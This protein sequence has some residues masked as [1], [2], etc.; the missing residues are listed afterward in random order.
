MKKAYLL[1]IYLVF[2]ICSHI[3]AQNGF[4]MCAEWEPALG[5]L[6]RWPLGIPSSLVVELAE[7][8]SLYVLVENQSQENQAVSNFSSWGV[9]LDH[10]VFIY[11]DTYSHWTRDWGPHYTFDENGVGGITDP[12][13]NGY[14]WVDGCEMK[15][16]GNTDDPVSPQ[17]LVDAKGYE[18]DDAVNGELASEFGC[19]IRFFPAYLT[20]GNIMVDGHF[21]AIS[22]DQML[23]ENS[24]IC[25]ETTFRSY[26]EDHLGITN[27]HFVSNPEVHGIQHIDC[28]AK[29][30]DEE[31]VLVKQVDS[32]HEEYNCIERLAE[33]ISGLTTCYGR[34]VEVKRIYCGSY[35]GMSVAA[36]TNSLIMNGKVLVPMFGIFSDHIALGTFQEAMPGYEVIGFEYGS[37]YY[38]DALH[39]RTKA[40]FDRQM[41][42]LWHKPL[43]EIQ[44]ESPEFEIMAMIDDR[45]ESGL[46]EDELLVYWRQ[47]GDVI[48]N[49]VD[50]QAI[51]A[52]DSFAADIPW[53]APGTTVEYYIAAADSSGRHET[54]PR[55]APEGF[56]S[57]TVD[58]GEVPCIEKGNYI[59]GTHSTEL[60]TPPYA[61]A[62]GYISGNNSY[63]DRHIAEK[64]RLYL[65]D[66]IP[67]RYLIQATLYFGVADGNGN[68][69]VIVWDNTGDSGSP[70][71][72][73]YTSDDIPINTIPVGIDNGYVVN[74]PSIHLTTDFF[75]GIEPDYGSGNEVALYTSADEETTGSGWSHYE[76]GEWHEYCES[77]NFGLYCSNAILPYICPDEATGEEETVISG[78]IMTYPNPSSGKVVISNTENA[79][80]TL[81]D[82]FG[83][84][85]LHQRSTDRNTV[86]DLTN[87]QDGTY[88]VKVMYD[89]GV[90]TGKI[91]V[92]K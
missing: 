60:I 71:N 65:Y 44:P 70:G 9:N 15:N 75:I 40:I 67:D 58:P 50:L 39:C 92:V 61:G 8:D 27:Y 85:I 86:L 64:F 25:D 78:N 7:D 2:I 91:C 59:P 33:E 36:Y 48:W 73:I 37:W 31:T 17:I 32:W 28:Y 89:H 52:V 80:V 69:K 38:Y 84:M 20:G 30:L 6:I 26:A 83:R 82:L 49:A 19:P 90:V 74:F 68:I 29:F 3:H 11:A 47:E 88:I 81:Y 10:C 16:Y 56:Y 24:G 51:A 41:L 21:T 54:L 35:D 12:Y 55:T 87:L 4:R 79:V 57:F 46:V 62:T 77:S 1:L 45:S 43:D 34:P 72:V 5:T 66:D 22:T 76:N 23:N 42:L 53:Q 63:N 13:F 18:E 14:P